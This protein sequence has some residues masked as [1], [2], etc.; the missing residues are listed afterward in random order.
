MGFRAALF[1]LGF[2]AAGLSGFVG[3]HAQVRSAGP[4]C[5]A[6]LVFFSSCGFVGL[7]FRVQG[8]EFRVDYGLGFL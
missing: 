2:R 5:Q 4:L 8:L 7:G 6:V 3:T 1:F